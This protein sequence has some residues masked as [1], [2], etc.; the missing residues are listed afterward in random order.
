MKKDFQ[1]AELPG[2]K[3]RKVAEIK[4]QGFRTANLKLYTTPDKN[5]TVRFFYNITSAFFIPQ[6]RFKAAGYYLTIFLADHSCFVSYRKMQSFFQL[7][8]QTAAHISFAGSAFLLGKSNFSPLSHS[9]EGQVDHSWRGKGES[10]INS[11]KQ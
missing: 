10:A 2:R 5:L 1:I 8:L 6:Y 7:K 11:K 9:G 3:C 4:Q